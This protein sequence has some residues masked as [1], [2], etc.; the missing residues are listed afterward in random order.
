MEND[1]ST[2]LEVWEKLDLPGLQKKLDVQSLE[3][4]STQTSSL[5]SRYLPCL[6][7]RK[8]LAEQTREFKKIAAPESVDFK[9]LL[10]LYQNEIDSINK[11]SKGAE[12]A[13]LNLYKLLAEV[14]DPT[15]TLRKALSQ[16]ESV[17]EIKS[18][19]QDN[20]KLKDSL[21]ILKDQADA[22]R[23][24]QNEADELREKLHDLE[25]MLET[26]AQDKAAELTNELRSEMEEKIK[27]YKDTEYSL[28]R[29]LN[30]TKDQ[31]AS[32]QSN[33]EF[34]QATTLTDH[35]SM[36]YRLTSFRREH[37]VKASGIGFDLV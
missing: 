2:A 27:M 16:A 25:S 12:T 21:Q 9:G 23:G 7:L 19:K 14:P 8:R 11:R 24:T 33:Q 31:F 13:F 35:F 17:Q 26:K 10:K 28:N 20:S 15:V 34:A 3:V 18:L 32:L 1:I 22:D 30:Q 29:Q 4:F 5:E 6:T 36:L 37:Y